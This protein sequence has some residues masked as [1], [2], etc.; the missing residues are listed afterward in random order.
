M[1]LRPA[2][3]PYDGLLLLD[4]VA[5]RPTLGQVFLP[6]TRYHLSAEAGTTVAEYLNPSGPSDAPCRTVAR[7]VAR[8]CKGPRGYGGSSPQAM[9]SPW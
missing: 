3:R 7:S 9:C 4:I 1:P 5:T 6:L 8:A 2:D